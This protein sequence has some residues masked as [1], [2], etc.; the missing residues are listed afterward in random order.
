MNNNNF[1][2]F[3]SIKPYPVKNISSD[4]IL[5]IRFSHS[6]HIIDM[7]KTIIMNMEKH[8]TQDSNVNIKAKSTHSHM[9]DIPGFNMLKD[10]ILHSCNIFYMTHN[11]SGCSLERENTVPIVTTMWG[12]RYQS[13]D[14]AQK[15]THW[16]GSLGYVYFIQ[17]PKNCPTLDFPDCKH[18]VKPK[19]RLLVL[20]P[21]HFEH[22]VKP[23][24]F[25]GFR[26][27]VAGHI[28]LVYNLPA[29]CRP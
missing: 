18:V 5:H 16:P 7:N 26:Y 3:K 14:S 10:L 4:S 6:D 12:S 24:V 8:L 25:E 19:D 2:D 28:S 22:E 29:Y 1:I 15:H 23:K 17:P 11:S 9:I 13:E 21:G 20:F 27:I